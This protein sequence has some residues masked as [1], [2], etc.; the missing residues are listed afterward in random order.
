MYLN[1]KWVLI[2]ALW[3]NI[4]L[5]FWHKPDEGTRTAWEQPDQV[6]IIIESHLPFFD[7]CSFK[8]LKPKS[9][10][11][12]KILTQPQS[13]GRR[14]RRQMECFRRCP[15]TCSPVHKKLITWDERWHLNCLRSWCKLL[16]TLWRLKYNF[17][18]REDLVTKSSADHLS[19]PEWY[20][21]GRL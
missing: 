5:D 13:P 3:R 9:E 12:Q 18:S 15:Y 4:C 1:I 10:S 17:N 11:V 7:K 16:S 2:F 8:D 20:V 14:G 6:Q 19:Q 21:W